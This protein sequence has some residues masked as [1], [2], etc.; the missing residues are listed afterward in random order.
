MAEHI[1]F[2]SSKEAWKLV[3][4]HYPDSDI[5]RVPLERANDFIPLPGSVKLWLDPGIDGLDDI[6]RRRSTSAR[7]N[8]W[9]EFIKQFPGFNCIADPSFA[10]NP[11]AGI[12]E[13]F[14][15]AVLN[16]SVK[17]RPA[18]ITVPQ[19]PFV[20]GNERNKIN[21]AMAKATG[22][23]KSSGRFTGRLVLPIIFTHQG[24][25]NLKTDRNP[26]VALA[27]RCYHDA[28]ADAFWVVDASLTDDSGSKMLRNTRFPAVIALHQE[29][30]QRIPCKLRIGGPYWGLNLVLWARG[31]VEHPAIGVGN[32][33]QY[34]LSGG[35]ANVPATCV[36]IG[37]LRRRVR[38]SQKLKLWLGESMDILGPAHP[39][40]SQFS[41]IRKQFALLQAQ[42]PAREQVARFY[43][44]WFDSIAASPSAG[45]SMALYQ[46]L[47]AAYALGRSLPEI[48]GEDTA[49][50]PE[51]IAEPLMLNCI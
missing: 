41:K 39:A 32:S 7:T 31:L 11:D 47:S 8:T 36:A 48:E 9:Y 40:H 33:Y 1:P 10:S 22:R 20:H 2:I 6:D 23:W 42:N 26:K 14:V 34:F 27:E 46:D 44:R 45:R 18:W 30:S 29:L 13:R 28:Q 12:V 49:R 35:R 51:A 3:Q 50:R 17:Y 24:Q 5:A 4:D 16:A 37:R 19:L 15:N 21:R 38:V 43:K 25:V